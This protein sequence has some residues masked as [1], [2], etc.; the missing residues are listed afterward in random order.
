MKKVVKVLIEWNEMGK[1]GIVLRR[2]YKYFYTKAIFQPG[3]KVGMI[4]GADKNGKLYI[5]DQAIR[6]HVF[7]TSKK[8][9]LGYGIAQKMLSRM[10]ARKAREQL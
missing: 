3:Q 6:F 8:T 9:I 2:V 10:P 1:G 5:T 7:G 4:V